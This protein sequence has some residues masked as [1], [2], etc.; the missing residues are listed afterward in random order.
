MKNNIV[1]GD[2]SLTRNDYKDVHESQVVESDILN[3]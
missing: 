2:K 3:F 1:I